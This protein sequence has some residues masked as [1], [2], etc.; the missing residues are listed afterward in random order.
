MMR[1]HMHRW[2]HIRRI[3][4]RSLVR[5]RPILHVLLVV[6]LFGVVLSV[7]SVNFFFFLFSIVPTLLL[8]SFSIT[9]GVV[10]VVS[11]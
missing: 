6:I 9:L 5:I 11:T 8:L 1:H 2:I 10:M 3:I 4:V 7:T